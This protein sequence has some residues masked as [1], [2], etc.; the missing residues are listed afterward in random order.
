MKDQ[1]EKLNHLWYHKNDCPKVYILKSGVIK[2]VIGKSTKGML[3]LI[4]YKN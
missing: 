3:K 2:N 4:K 1:S